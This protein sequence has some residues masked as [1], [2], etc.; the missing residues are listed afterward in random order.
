MSKQ[1]QSR[2]NN[3][4]L[5]V[6]E[7]KLSEFGFGSNQ[8]LINKSELAKSSGGGGCCCCC[9][10]CCCGGAADIKKL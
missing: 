4:K 3:T 8:A 7:N 10:C 6:P 1:I 5:A 9:C 2:K